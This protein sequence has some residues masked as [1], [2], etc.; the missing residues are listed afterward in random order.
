MTLFGRISIIFAFLPAAATFA[1]PL[2][3]AGA[4]F[5]QPFE[6]AGVAGRPIPLAAT[7]V[8]LASSARFQTLAHAWSFE[9]QLAIFFPRCNEDSELAL[10]GQLTGN[11]GYRV[12]SRVVALAGAGLRAG[13]LFSNGHEVERSGTFVTA[14]GTGV[15]WLFLLDA[16][17]AYWL[18]EK[19]RLDAQSSVTGFLSDETRRFRILLGVSYAI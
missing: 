2:L 19:I 7:P 4:L 13:A 15:A 10:G 16:G 12:N 5:L 6:A 18:D 3:G 8:L 17:L 1:S 9:P 14:A 11:L